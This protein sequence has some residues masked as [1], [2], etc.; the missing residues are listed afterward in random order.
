MSSPY[1][2][3]LAVRYLRFHRG[4][5]FLSVITAI[6]VAGV[7]VGTAA[8]VIAL[9]LMTGFTEGVRERILRGSAHLQVL[10]AH[11][12]GFPDA[13]RLAGRIEEVPGVRA[14]APVLFSPAMVANEA[15]GLP[16]YAELF[17]VEP[18]RQARVADFGSAEPL[19]VLAEPDPG[20][21]PGVV[22]GADLAKRLGVAEGDAVR[23]TVPR[24]RLTP[25]AP[26]PRTLSARVAGTFRTDAYPQ[27]A[28]RVYLDLR[29]V[30]RLLGAEGETSWVEVRL[31][32][33]RE[34]PLRKREIQATLGSDW[35]V[36]DLLE[37]NRDILRALNTEK[38]ILF[39]AIGLIVVVASLNVVSTLILM[40][41]DKVREI[42]ALTAMGAR[43]GGIASVFVLQG[44]VIGV[45][46]SVL[47][48]VLGTAAAWWLDAYEV[49]RL[50]PD[51]YFISHVPF[52]TR[53]IDVAA[54]SLL[55]VGVSL[56][57]TIYPAWKAA[58]LRPVEAIRHE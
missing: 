26:I 32:A 34:L 39:L 55:A 54:V 25:F 47:G 28:Q 41:H 29:E 27:D 42:G 22:L 24:L 20:G 23:F 50:D 6:S 7:T 35:V 15:A 58:S 10:S 37:Q 48:I 33:L 49:I 4:R 1:E 53:S 38:L 21:S 12:S 56:V 2:F 52:R 51:V 14:A 13:D 45:V 40:V 30:R 18:E 5:G 11:G 3:H 17:G 9:S 46:G 8:L 36:V 31:E 19:A 43:R 16:A 57:A 44:L